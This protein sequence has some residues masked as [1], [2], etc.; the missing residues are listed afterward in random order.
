M[1]KFYSVHSVLSN[2]LV[3]QIIIYL[4]KSRSE[5]GESVEEVLA[6]HKKELQEYALKTF[7]ALI[8]EENIYYEIVSGESIDERIEIKKVFNRL[9]DDDIK[10]VLVVE[11]Q[12]LTRGD[13]ED[14]GRVLNI[15]KY[16]PNN[17]FVLTPN[18]LYDLQD[19]FDYK[20]LKMELLQGNEY[21]EYYKMITKRGKKSSFGEGRFISSV[22]PFG[23][24]KEKLKDKGFKLIINKEEAPVV[25]MIFELFVESLGTQ[26]LAD[27]LNAEGVQSRSG[28]EWNYGMVRNILVN[29]TY[30]GCL[31]WEK[32]QVL[33][34]MIEGRVVK[35]RPKNENYM[36]VKGLHE[37]LISK[38]LFDLAQEKIKNHPNSRLVN[39]E[40][41]NALSG[42]VFCSKCG[43]S[44]V[45][46]PN[47]RKNQRQKV[48]KYKIDKQALSDLLRTHKDES[49][50]TLTQIA[51][52]L[53]VSRNIVVGWFSLKIEKMN[54]SFLFSEKWADLKRLLKIKTK[55]FDKSILTFEEPEERKDYIMCSNSRCS[56][57]ASCLEIVER[58]ILKALEGELKH[59]HYFLDNYEQETKKTIKS[60]KRRLTTIDNKIEALKN[61][62]KNSRREYNLGR[63]SYEDYIE[64][65]ESYEKEIEGLNLEREKYV[66]KENEEIVIQY[67][68]A[69]P[70]IENCIKE[71]HNISSITEKN[72]L[73]KSIIE[74]VE[75]TKNKRLNW[76]RKDVDDLELKLHLKI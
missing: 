34:K 73:L 40:L 39:R 16:S 37:P 38:E 71:Y 24:D 28:K 3:H 36:I 35:Y 74:K 61:A 11:P 32:R 50:L 57:V 31:V 15:F 12:R 2:I 5:D 56:N 64:D 66:N 45:R 26:E 17:T 14:C 48:R 75:Y 46:Q 13:L 21:L 68:K 72:L 76:K 67:K 51:N 30:Y 4:R 41:K 29:E 8:P 49:G 42:I 52:E 65:K 9:N 10:G 58:G 22:A 25:K 33:K 23:Y 54:L 47:T 63:F 1:E 20:I 6:R 53:D 44:M 7:G 62:I 19:S 27:F 70:I 59:F 18:K 60:N 69:I 43:R 55:K